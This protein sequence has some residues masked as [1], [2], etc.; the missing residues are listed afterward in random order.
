MIRLR[1]AAADWEL[2]PAGQSTGTVDL[3][4]Q[5]QSLATVCRFQYCTN[6]ATTIVLAGGCHIMPEHVGKVLVA[7][8]VCLHSK[9]NPV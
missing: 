5:A 6:M 4:A 7:C 3:S 1:C 8:T 2:L 9:I